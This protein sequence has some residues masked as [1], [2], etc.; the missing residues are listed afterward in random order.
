MPENTLFSRFSDADEKSLLDLHH[1]AWSK[2]EK[3]II[4]RDWRGQPML[5]QKGY[6]WKN[7]TEIAS[8]WNHTHLFFF[9]Q[10]WFD[11]LNLSLD[12]PPNQPVN[13]LWETDVVEVF[14][15]PESCEDYFELEFSP[16]GQWLDVHVLQPR[17]DVNFNWKSH[18]KVHAEI[19]EKEGTWHVIA[20]IPLESIK[21]GCLFQDSAREGQC[22]RLNLYRMAGTEPNREFLAWRPTFTQQPDFHVPASFGNILFLKD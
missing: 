6:N 21:Q 15:K 3:V 18:V 11:E 5:R 13:Q 19:Q 1:S 10:C 2:C 12:R 14:L 7:L 20:S 17:V 16:L 9:F 22:W 4:D 8:L